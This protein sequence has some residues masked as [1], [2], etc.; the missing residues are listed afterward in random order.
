MKPT[1]G[2]R[3]QLVFI[4]ARFLAAAP[5]C[6]TP[7]AGPT[8]NGPLRLPPATRFSQAKLAIEPY[9]HYTRHTCHNITRRFTG[10]GY[11]GYGLASCNPPVTCADAY[12]VVAATEAAAA[13]SVAMQMQTSQASVHAMYH[14]AFWIPCR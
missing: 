14:G 1:N 4:G 3:L 10:T 8:G 5:I 2:T 7:V 12:E 9:S 11:D 13:R 6:P